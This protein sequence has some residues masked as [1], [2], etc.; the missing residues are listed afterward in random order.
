M[1]PAP[2]PSPTSSA[3]PPAG[4]EVRGSYGLGPATAEDTNTD[5]DSD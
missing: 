2:S 1:R 4:Q 3:S 5:E